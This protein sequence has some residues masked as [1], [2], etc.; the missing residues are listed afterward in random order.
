MNKRIFTASFSVRFGTQ[1]IRFELSPAPLHGGGE[2][3]FRVRI[4]R[5]WHDGAD[6]QPLFLDQSMLAALLAQTAL[7]D[8]PAPPLPAPLPPMPALSNKMRI[9]VPLEQDKGGM[10]RYEGTWTHSP[11]ILAHD[12]RWM[13]AVFL[14]GK[15]VVFVPCD[16]VIPVKAFKETHHVRP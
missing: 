2:G 14:L 10:P 3:L 8:M 16:D 1:R 15:G 4:N 6:G 11:P 9:S 13:I 5:R 7:G 12:G